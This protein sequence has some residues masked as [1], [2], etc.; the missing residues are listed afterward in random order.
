MNCKFRW[1]NMVF[2]LTSLAYPSRIA[3][4]EYHLSNIPSDMTAHFHTMLELPG[5]WDYAASRLGN[6]PYDMTAHFHTMIDTPDHWDCG[7]AHLE[8]IF[9]FPIDHFYKNLAV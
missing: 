4:P 9:R 6:I 3:Q 8:N 1:I 5:H 7:G 2:H